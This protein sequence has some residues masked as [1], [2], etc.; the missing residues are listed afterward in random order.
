MRLTDWPRSELQ[1]GQEPG[2]SHTSP[3][4]QG[5]KPGNNQDVGR[6]N[7]WKFQG[8]K[9][10]FPPNAYGFVGLSDAAL[11]SR[12]HWSVARHLKNQRKSSAAIPSRVAAGQ[13]RSVSGRE[14]AGR[15]REALG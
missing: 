14:A 6:L 1:L 3:S 8:G 15:C 9:N 5:S 4:T 13:R 10:T 7:N 11:P 12:R 2:P